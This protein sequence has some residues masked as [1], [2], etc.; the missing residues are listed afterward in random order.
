MHSRAINIW[1][2]GVAHDQLLWIY[3]LINNSLF[4]YDKPLI[5][6]RRHEGNATGFSGRLDTTRKKRAETSLRNARVV[7]NIYKESS[8]KAPSERQFIEDYVKYERLRAK[9]LNERRVISWIK[10]NVKYR[11]YVYSLRSCLKDLYY[12]LQKN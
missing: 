7:E 11:Q 6:F 4:I 3:A 1:E 2:C 10:Y 5:K 9:A 8:P 12:V